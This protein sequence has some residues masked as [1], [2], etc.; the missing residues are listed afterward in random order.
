MLKKTATNL[1]KSLLISASMLLFAL[2]AIGS[3]NVLKKLNALKINSTKAVTYEGFEMTKEAARCW[4]GD[5][6]SLH[7]ENTGGTINSTYIG[8]IDVHRKIR[9]S[10][11]T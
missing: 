3:G 5:P 2:N 8:Y 11:C 10:G 6:R 7:Y 4:F 1:R 9:Y